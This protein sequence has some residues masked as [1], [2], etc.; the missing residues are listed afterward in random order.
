[1]EE[2]IDNYFLSL[3]EPEQSTLLFLHSFL[4]TEIAL[5]YKRKFNTPFYYYNG[6]WF[7][8]VDYNPRKRT[9]H[10]S[11]VKGNKVTHPKLLSE[12]RKQMKIYKI[13]PLKDVDTLELQKIIALLKQEY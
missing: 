1:M 7:C 8:F 10:I 5:E 3:P 12:G 6:K 13:D 4:N 9:I 11:F 2:H